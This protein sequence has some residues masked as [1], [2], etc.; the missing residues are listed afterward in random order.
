MTSS[1]SRIFILLI[2]LGSS[3]EQ[4]TFTFR[5][6]YDGYIYPSWKKK[7]KINEFLFNDAVVVG[8]NFMVLAGGVEE[9]KG[10]S[11]LFSHSICLGMAKE[12][13]KFVPNQINDVPKMLQYA[14]GYSKQKLMINGLQ[15]DTRD[16][17]TTLVYMKLVGYQ[18]V[19]GVVGNSGFSV[20]RYNKQT[21]M[22]ELVKK[23][24]EDMSD[25]YTPKKVTADVIE[26]K[27]DHEYKVE[28]GDI[29]MAYSDGVSDVVPPSFIT[30]V[31]NFL[32]AKMIN[33]KREKG[34]LY[35]LD[36]DYDYDLAEF[37]EGYVQNLNELDLNVNNNLVYNLF[38]KMKIDYKIYQEKKMRDN[39]EKP[40]FE[41]KNLQQFEVPKFQQK[42]PEHAN[43]NNQAE[44]QSNHNQ[45]LSKEQNKPLQ[46]NEVPM[47]QQPDNHKKVQNISYQGVQWRNQYKDEPLEEELQFQQFNKDFQ[48]KMKQL[49]PG[50]KIRRSM[51]RIFRSEVCNLL[52]PTGNN[53]TL[54][55][56]ASF[57]DISNLISIQS[58]QD[59]EGTIKSYDC[60]RNI[61]IQKTTNRY[62][63][64]KKWT[65]GDMIDLTYP[66]HP[67]EENYSSLSDCVREV[68]PEFPKDVS[69]E[70]IAEVFNSRYFARNIALAVKYILNDPRVAD[71]YFILKTFITAKNKGIVLNDAEIAQIKDKFA[72]KKGDV[73][74][75]ASAI[76]PV[77]PQSTFN[78]P[79]PNVDDMKILQRTIEFHYL[80]VNSVF[81][82][83]NNREKHKN[84][85]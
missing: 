27:V 21:G 78:Q 56:L 41:R 76:A 57:S 85:I 63:N 52:D 68:I 36:Y 84:I 35:K 39:Q 2:V 69:R 7:G 60:F 1:L 53:E 17:A 45:F 50:E 5:S 58:F 29:V 25:L 11:G 16:V 37:V 18:L 61:E 34:L 28:V 54:K 71:K 73:S 8:E 14:L 31:T 64:P 4:L 80:A 79:E 59:I 12:F 24:E 55:I 6:Q 77:T 15:G 70:E 32:V 72:A 66:I 13:E 65:C 51:N 22:I 33:R 48:N 3:V 38:E 82:E 83:F 10:F 42:K 20:F 75:A 43:V 44:K 62:S 47:K 74:I 26:K 46:Q 67:I 30:A 40:G 9:S 49:T 23:S 81:T 19:A